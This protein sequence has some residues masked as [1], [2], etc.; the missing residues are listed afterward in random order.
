MPDF[1]IFKSNKKTINNSQIKNDQ[2]IIE[3]L[4]KTIR[5]KT[6][7]D[8]ISKV[9]ILVKDLSIDNNNDLISPF[10][11][12]QPR[13]YYAIHFD[14]INLN[15]LSKELDS[16]IIYVGFGLDLNMQRTVLGFWIQAGSE[17][18][19]KFWTKVCKELKDSGIHSVEIKENHQQYW[20]S[21]AMR[22]VFK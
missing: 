3:S 2:I 7:E 13:S 14:S 8:F 15:T 10:R 20:L 22:Q 11:L 17:T 18:P 21:E 5:H 16:S 12:G 4:L 1:K 9:E 6:Y 19:Y